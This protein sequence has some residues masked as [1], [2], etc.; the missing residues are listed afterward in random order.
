[1]RFVSFQLPDDRLIP[2]NDDVIY[3]SGV[4]SP[5]SGLWPVHR[6]FLGLESTASLEGIVSGTQLVKTA[7]GLAD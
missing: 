3:R 1:M 7:E 2:C 5:R 6:R 4:F